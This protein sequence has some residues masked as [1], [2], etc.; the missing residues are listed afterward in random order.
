MWCKAV[1]RVPLTG[2]GDRLRGPCGLENKYLH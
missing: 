2:L 1:G